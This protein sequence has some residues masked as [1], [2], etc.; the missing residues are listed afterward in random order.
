[1]ILFPNKF[2]IFAIIL[3]VLGLPFSFI[4]WQAHTPTIHHEPFL[5][6]TAQ[7]QPCTSIRTP[8]END[9]KKV[10]VAAHNDTPQA[11]CATSQESRTYETLHGLG[12][13]TLSKEVTLANL[14]V[15]G[16]I[17]AWLHGSFLAIGPGKFEVQKS[18]ARHWF[19]GF[20][21]MHRFGIQNGAVTYANKLLQTNYLH[22][23]LAAG[24]MSN[25]ACASNPNASF[26]SKVAGA[27]SSS[28]KPRYDNTN[29]NTVHMGTCCIA[30]TESPLSCA[31]DP[32]TLETQQ[33]FVYQD[34]FEPHM[35]CAHPLYDTT[36]GMWYG[37]ATT[38]GNTSTYTIYTYNPKTA[39]RTIL[40]A[41]QS[42]YPAYIHSFSMTQQYIVICEVPFVL[43]PYDLLLSSKPFI[44]NYQ[45]KPQ[46][47]TTIHLI[48][49]N[50]KKIK[51]TTTQSFFTLHHVNAF[52]ENGHVIVDVCA[53]NDAS[54]IQAFSLEPL[55]HQK[56]HRFPRSSI[57]RLVID[58]AHKK[59]TVTRHTI[60]PISFE[61]PSINPKHQGK[62]Y[63]FAY[64]ASSNSTQTF[65]NVLTKINCNS[66]KTIEWRSADCFVTQPVFVAHPN[67]TLEDDGV[68]LSIVLDAKACHSF[69]LIL[70]AQ[71]FQE[72]GR[73]PVPHHIPF[74]VHNNFYAE[75][76]HTV[77]P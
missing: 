10:M 68:V 41:L 51:T 62:V 39:R 61:T 11:A 12:F 32:E 60:N 3:V 35:V 38:F 14:P 13:T 56:D 69:L 29:I 16:T 40:A 54:V 23:S 55:L 18:R 53:Y 25:A 77:T 9:T 36:T 20:A 2:K 65:F 43:N 5:A 67:G 48:D 1:M 44:E 4:L 63:H 15:Q 37:I 27:F 21:M 47:G 46:M 30:V 76:P 73:V 28:A 42:S 8:D 45:W 49:R 59:P 64:G 19:D 17:P 33:P 57:V 71:T 24:Q 34:A 26:F 58:P 70:D 50:T 66:G 52:E 74:T 6:E 22:E 31:Y 75:L 7:A 72:L